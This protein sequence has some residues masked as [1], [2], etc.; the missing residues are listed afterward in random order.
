M[1]Q[2]LWAWNLL[3]NTGIQGEG[4]GGT[5]SYEQTVHIIFFPKA[6]ATMAGPTHGFHDGVLCFFLLSL[7]W[8]VGWTYGAP[9]EPVMG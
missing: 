5:Q 6:S 3:G 1:C 7:L 9:V 4:A 8:A 2:I